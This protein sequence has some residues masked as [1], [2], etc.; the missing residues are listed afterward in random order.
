MVAATASLT[1]IAAIALFMAME[2]V[3]LKLRVA[4]VIASA[5]LVHQITGPGPVRLSGPKILWGL[6]YLVVQVGVFL[7]RI[8]MAMRAKRR[9]LRVVIAGQALQR[10]AESRRVTN[11]VMIL[12]ILRVL[13]GVK[14]GLVRTS[15]IFSLALFRFPRKLRRWP[16]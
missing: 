1:R 9:A 11:Q 3:A 12:R 10:H 7:A 13:R 6:L 14:R 8:T 4:R 2:I 15:L 16:K 5:V